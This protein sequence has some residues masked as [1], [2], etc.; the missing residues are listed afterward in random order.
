VLGY[1]QLRPAKTL[2]RLALR[3]L[4]S[5]DR[6]PGPVRWAS[7][8]VPEPRSGQFATTRPEPDLSH[9]Q[10]CFYSLSRPARVAI[11]SGESEYRKVAKQPNA[12]EEI[13]TSLDLKVQGT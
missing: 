6:R 8:D 1:A 10:A 2:S 13:L 9:P 5:V 12:S 3:P 7:L 11:G 4:I